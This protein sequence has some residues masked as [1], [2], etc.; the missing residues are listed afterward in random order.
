MLTAA[1]LWRRPYGPALLLASWVF[2]LGNLYAMLFTRLEPLN[3]A[4]RPWKLLAVL[5]VWAAVSSLVALRHTIRAP[6]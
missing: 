6:Q 1:A 4:G 5:V 3:P 2:V